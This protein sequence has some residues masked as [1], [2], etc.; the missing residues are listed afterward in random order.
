MPWDGGWWRLGDIVR[1][2]I[3]STLSILKTSSLL[4]NEILKFRND[5]CKREV[6]KG[7]TEPPYYYIIPREQA[8]Q[9][10]FVSLVRL[11]KEH[12]VNASLLSEN[13]TLNGINLKAGDVVYPLA[14]PF[15][16]FVKEVMEKQKFPVRHYTP[17]GEIVRPYDVASWS[18]P[19]HRGIVSHEISTRD[20]AFEGK[21]KAL[22][23]DYNPFREGYRYPAI[24]PVS[25]NGS[26]RAAFMALQKGA[27]VERLLEGTT[28]NGRYYGKGSFVITGNDADL[29]NNI[30][31][32]SMTEPDAVSQ[33]SS[34]ALTP[35]TLPRIALTE[36][37]FSDMDAGWTRYLFDIYHI[38]YTVIRPDE[39]EKIDLSA[40]YDIL[41]LP[42]NGKAILMNGKPGTEGGAYM[43]NYH[44]DYQKGM[45][46][47]GLENILKFVN[48]GGRVLSW[49]QSADLFTGLLEVAS[50]DAKEEFVLP[51]ANDAEQA[52]KDGLFVPGSLVKVE[53]NMNHPLTYGMPPETGVFY[54]GNPLFSTSIPRFDMDRRV[55]G[56]FPEEGI[57]LSGYG[58]NE[59]KMA[60]KAAM[61]WVE[62][63][64]GDIILYAF[65]PQF[66][67]STQATYKLLFN[68][69]FPEKTKNINAQ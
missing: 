44:P 17:G 37:Y 29:L 27:R 41:I 46:K 34:L 53:L 59:E 69:L 24:F 22:R 63:G 31:K 19:L 1:L 65:N 36:T 3:E 43:S 13:Y 25:S 35:V 2:E 58:E 60:G 68:A 14:Q 38:P 7:R 5:L 50:G 66:R 39:F 67:A 45:G 51:F 49:G 57:L 21:L 30:V 54:R 20:I 23:E 52:R 8:D 48:Q 15:R 33:S 62:K 9:S 11:M 28:I 18:L 32:E 64:K 4:K 16:A 55:I 6:E 56:S 26:F 12:G 47:K 40:L 10:E 42:N 61:V